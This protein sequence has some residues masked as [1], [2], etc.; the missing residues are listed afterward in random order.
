MGGGG[1]VKNTAVYYKV[2]PMNFLTHSQK[3]PTDVRQTGP[4]GTTL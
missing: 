1:G 2:L 4:C 3:S